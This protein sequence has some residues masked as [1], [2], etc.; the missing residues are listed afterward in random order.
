MKALSSAQILER[1]QQRLPL[2]TGGAR[3]LPER[4]HTLRATIEWSYELLSSEEQSL[5][6][7]LSVFSG[8]CTLEAA[9]EIAEAHL[10]ILQSL[11]DKSLVRHTQ[12]RFWMLETIREY[13]AG[14]L[15]QSGKAEQLRRRH[16]RHFLALAEEA[17]PH[18][19]PDRREWLDRL[20]REHDNL[21]AAFD[22]FESSSETQHA[23][24]LAGALS[25]FWFTRGHLVEGRR[26]LESALRADERPTAARAKAL[27]KASLMGGENATVLAEEGLALNRK[28]GE[29]WGIAQSEL[30]LASAVA[31][32]DMAR[33]RELYEQSARR[34][35]ELGDEHHVLIATRSLAWACI[36]LG[37][38]ERGRTLHEE[39]LRRAR[40]LSNERIEAITLGA[41][42]MHAV[43]DGRIEDAV[44]MLKESHRLHGE[45]GDPV[46][47]ALDVFRFAA[48]L[49]AEGRALTAARVFS[50]SDALCEEIG[51]SLRGWDPE[52]VEGTL[53]TIRKQ[54]DEAAFAE[55]WDQGR[56]LTAGEAV[57]LAL[58]S[59]D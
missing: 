29:P 26:R 53:A 24:R 2:L 23:L 32:D 44:P 47:T 35:R 1:L 57:A 54:L 21:R 33:A 9:E 40:A 36:N 55:A 19:P 22:W 46:Q 17:E 7:R 16:A 58:D 42:A 4:Q 39:N 34:F 15:D 6:A 45:L 28:L 14:R 50:S 8:G 56:R 20:D 51:F 13:A 18:L 25:R 43:E 48:L 49:A 59:L 5:F 52:F 12:E 3:D 38:R 11:V 10:D 41:L 31:E 27:N 37:D 30:A